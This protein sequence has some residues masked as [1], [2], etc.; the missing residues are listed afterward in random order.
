M[1]LYQFL[2][3]DSAHSIEIIQLKHKI[4]EAYTAIE[5]KHFAHFM[6]V[7]NLCNENQLENFD[8]LTEELSRLFSGPPPRKKRRK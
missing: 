6:D 7:K 4:G 2:K 5:T 8:E 3:S 1:W